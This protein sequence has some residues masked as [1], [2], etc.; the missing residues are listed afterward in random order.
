MK[1]FLESG[2]I[3]IKYTKITIWLILMDMIKILCKIA[4]GLKIDENDLK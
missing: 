4:N 3:V 1:N 2:K